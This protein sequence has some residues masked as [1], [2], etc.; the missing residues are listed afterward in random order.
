MLAA[1]YI[2][3]N[4]LHF[5]LSLFFPPHPICRYFYL[6]LLLLGVA[7]L[8]AFLRNRY[9]KMIGHIQ[10]THECRALHAT[11]TM[12]IMRPIEISYESEFIAFF[13]TPR[14]VAGFTRTILINVYCIFTRDLH[15][16]QKYNEKIK[17]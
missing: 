11:Y 14:E 16:N 1:K 10:Y 9:G 2:R 13:A 7:N 8:S 15:G 6:L 4:L 3:M 17:M 5:S 12:P